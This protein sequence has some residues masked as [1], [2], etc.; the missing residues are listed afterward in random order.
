MCQTNMWVAI[1]SGRG[2]RSL[3]NAT[4]LDVDSWQLLPVLLY[5]D[6]EVSPYVDLQ[7]NGEVWDADMYD[8]GGCGTT[9]RNNGFECVWKE[10]T[11]P[12]NSHSKEQGR[13]VIPRV[14]TLTGAG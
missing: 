14:V 3:H 6:G 4:P 2:H 7:C 1:T 5:G 12:Q 9:R 8:P 13:S 10:V 11:H